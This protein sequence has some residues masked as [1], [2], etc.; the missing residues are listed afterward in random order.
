[1]VAWHQNEQNEMK[2]KE[3]TKVF[4]HVIS[5][6]RVLNRGLLSLAYILHSNILRFP[7]YLMFMVDLHI[8]KYITPMR[9]ISYISIY[10]AHAPIHRVKKYFFFN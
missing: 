7:Q 2:M 1:M 6:L 10:H 5:F 8:S 4:M 3:I 9:D